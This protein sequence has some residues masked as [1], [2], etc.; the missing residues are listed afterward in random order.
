M[1]RTIQLSALIIVGAL[2]APVASQAAESAP[3]P[4]VRAEVQIYDRAHKDSHTW[5]DREDRH[6]R[7]YL[8]EQHRKYV[9]FNRL[10]RTRQNE[11]WNWR[12]QHPN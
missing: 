1:K 2:L 9:A 6:Y 5:N 8:A 12:H 7:A 4:Q 10:S 11:Y 3:G